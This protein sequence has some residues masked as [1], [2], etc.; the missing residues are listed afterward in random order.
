MRSITGMQNLDRICNRLDKEIIYHRLQ[1]L[2]KQHK[3]LIHKQH[4]QL[5]PHQVKILKQEIDELIASI[6][7]VI[8][9]KTHIQQD[10]KIDT[11]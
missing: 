7:H 11:T 2:E 9:I 1:L 4:N 8:E 3:M 6:N 5:K 10:Y